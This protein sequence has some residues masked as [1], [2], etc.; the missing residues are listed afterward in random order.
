ML[1]RYS[2]SAQFQPDHSKTRLH[3]TAGTHARVAASIDASSDVCT[4]AN[5]DSSSSSTASVS[6]HACVYADTHARLAASIYVSSDVCID[7]RIDGSID[8]SFDVAIRCPVPSLV[9]AG[10]GDAFTLT[11]P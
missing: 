4:E 9:A 10:G 7:A 1:W 2:P 5:D 11:P 3:P 8:R 6:T